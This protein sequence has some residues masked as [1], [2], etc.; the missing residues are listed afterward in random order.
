MKALFA[1]GGEPREAAGG[2]P[3]EAAGGRAGWTAWVVCALAMCLL[4]AAPAR[5]AENR[6]DRAAAGLKTSPLYVHPELGYLLSDQ[7]RAT[8]LDALRGA[9]L[10]FDVRVA[11]MPSVEA[12]ESGGEQD[13]MLWALD[14]RL[15]RAKRLLIGLDQHGNFELVS[16]RLRRDIDVPFEVQYAR[17]G[18][19]IVP[20]F[21]A[22]LQAVKASKTGYY[23]RERP[24]GPPPPLTENLPDSDYD[25]SDGGST[26]TLVGACVGGLFAGL[27]GWWLSVAIRWVRRA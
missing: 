13:R 9:D 10:P 15:P 17:D 22:I 16:A 26:W 8:M 11:V 27:L 25:E 5:A 6:L 21:R 23:E 3:R 18:T 14:D 24:S 19:G 1:A 20:R 4:L 7:D 2:E 12:D